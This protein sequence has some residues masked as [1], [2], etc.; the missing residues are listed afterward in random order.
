M[1][2]YGRAVIV[3]SPSTFGKGTVQRFIDL[4]RTIRG[5]NELKPLG[6]IKLTTQKFY[7]VNGGSTQLRGVTPDIILP[8]NFFYIKTGERDREYAMEWTEIDPVEYDQDVLEVAARY[9]TPAP[10]MADFTLGL[11]VGPRQSWPLMLSAK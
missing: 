8:D 3:G 2:D 7:R 11:S 4:D 6:E 9:G 1:Q 5:F 10:P